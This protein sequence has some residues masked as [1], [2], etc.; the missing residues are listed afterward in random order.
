MSDSSKEVIPYFHSFWKDLHVKSGCLCVDER[1]AI[2]NSIKAAVFESKHMTHPGSWGMTSLSQYAWW[3][4][5]HREIFAK[6]SDCVPFTEI[7]SRT[8]YT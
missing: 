2:P 5:M 3:P 8:Y 6:T 7:E 1:V 4:Y